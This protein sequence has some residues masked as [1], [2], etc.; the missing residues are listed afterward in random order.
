[1]SRTV[2]NHMQSE[3]KR[4]R[5][6][7]DEAR[8]EVVKLR[9]ELDLASND[10]K[11]KTNKIGELERRMEQQK[12]TI[13]VQSDQISGPREY[14]TPHRSR[15]GAQ[16]HPAIYTQVP[17]TYMQPPPAYIQ[18]A[19]NVNRHEGTTSP[20]VE[21]MRSLSTKTLT[22]HRQDPHVAF[23]EPVERG[24]TAFQTGSGVGIASIQRH[25]SHGPGSRSR[26]EGFE[27]PYRNKSAQALNWRADG[28]D[29]Q[30]PP[31]VIADPGAIV[32][33]G[34]G[35]TQVAWP[36]E[37]SQFFKLTEDWARNYANVPDRT[38]DK[39]LPSGLRDAFSKQ[40]D[41]SL[42]DPLLASGSTRYFLVAKLLNS[43]MST[44][45]FRTQSSRGFSE[46][47]DNKLT[48][49][50][51]EI[52]PQIPTHFRYALMVAIAD[53]AKDMQ[54]SAG[55]QEFIEEQ[56]SEKMKSLW[57]RLTYLFAPGLEASQAWD[58]LEHIF[59]EAF[60]ISN[61]MMCTPFSYSF[62]YPAA[63]SNS[64]FNPSCMINRD[65]SFKGD[66][67]SLKRQGLRVRLGITPIV[68]VTN[69]MG[70]SITPQTVH[71]ANVLLMH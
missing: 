53:T 15:T 17:P 55:F 33:Q 12:K 52:Q 37:F 32:V 8:S 62:S 42:V 65:V 63:R 45:L 39:D 28:F 3:N 64:Y 40:S 2:N 9:K 29:N 59:H 10:L 36:S 13:Q 35:S 46:A 60:R 38:A 70:P 14:N 61:V 5:A 51:H 68:V 19:L 47:F 21:F 58:D 22:S 66:P 44:D 7:R 69:F 34:D 49:L 20:Q 57:D 30:A 11:A 16:Y 43:Y 56:K 71:F 6:E 4:L 48:D 41:L 50:R 67:L 26:N 25:N 54:K 1:M 18:P 24:Q 31:E 27:L 23:Y